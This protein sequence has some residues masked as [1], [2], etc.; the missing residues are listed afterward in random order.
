MRM[1]STRVLLPDD[2]DVESYFQRIGYAGPAN[3]TLETL[4]DIH[5]HH[6]KIIP[7]E[8]LDALLKRPIPLGAEAIGRKIL[9][10]GRGGWCFEQNLLFGNVLQSIGFR[11]TGLAAR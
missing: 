6:P 11:V 4:A 3:A 7:F 9:L 2:V 10:S 5:L 8:N 1:T